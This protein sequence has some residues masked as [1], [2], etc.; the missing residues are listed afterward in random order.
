MF[1]TTTFQIGNAPVP[2]IGQLQKCWPDWA[3]CPQRARTVSLMA[4]H[5]IHALFTPADIETAADGTVLRHELRCNY[6]RKP[7]ELHRYPTGKRRGKWRPVDPKLLHEHLLRGCNHNSDDI[8]NVASAATKEEANARVADIRTHNR[9]WPPP[10][11][12]ACDQPM[13]TATVASQ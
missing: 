10:T 6:C 11:T 8:R 12:I 7:W 9:P 4:A 3:I 2:L 13:V 1:T 5:P